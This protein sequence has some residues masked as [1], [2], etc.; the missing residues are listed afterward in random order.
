MKLYAYGIYGLTFN[1]HTCMW[2]YIEW[3][4]TCI[5]QH[6]RRA[7]ITALDSLTL[8]MLDCFVYKILQLFFTVNETVY[9]A[10]HNA[11]RCSFD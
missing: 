4:I 5:R 1:L 2:T 6:Q 11:A 9:C 3:N 8:R 7:K 10:M